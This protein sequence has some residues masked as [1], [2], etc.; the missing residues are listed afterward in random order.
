M[1]VAKVENA[2]SPAIRRRRRRLEPAGA[3]LLSSPR[4]TSGRSA[5]GLF[6]RGGGFVTEAGGLGWIW[7]TM[8]THPM[9]ERIGWKDF[10][11]QISTITH[12]Q[13]SGRAYTCC[14]T[15]G[16]SVGGSRR[17]SLESKNFS[18]PDAANH[19]LNRKLVYH[20]RK[21]KGVRMLRG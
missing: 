14:V 9:H 21:Q 8:A 1:K 17:V 18:L 10:Q 12:F 7:F 19:L 11:H 15:I 3:Q 16:S 13:Q 4:A 5:N 6:C 2:A 20:A